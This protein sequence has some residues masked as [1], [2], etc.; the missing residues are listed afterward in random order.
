[1]RQAG[2]R[3]LRTGF[4]LVETGLVGAAHLELNGADEAERR[5]APAGIV[6]AVMSRVRASTA[7]VRVWKAVR[8]TN[9]LFSVLKNVSIV[10]SS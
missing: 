1:M 3:R 6:E 8:L 5:M 2:T 7:S 4:G 9:S 10:A